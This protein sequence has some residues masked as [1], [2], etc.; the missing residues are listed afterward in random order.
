MGILFKY[1]ARSIKKNI[2]PAILIFLS[3]AFSSAALYLNL[4]ISQD[5][6]EV[7]QKAFKGTSGGYDLRVE[8]DDGYELVDDSLKLDEA[9]SLLFISYDIKD[10]LLEEK[11]IH[12]LG[13][14]TNVNEI[15]DCEMISLKEGTLPQ[16]INE[17]IISESKAELYSYSVG[18]IIEFDSQEYIVT[19]IA[20]SLGYFGNEMPNVIEIISPYISGSKTTTFLIDT[21]MDPE[22]C[23]K[24]LESEHEGW[25]VDPFEENLFINYTGAIRAVLIIVILITMLLGGFIIY[26]VTSMMID[27]RMSAMASFRSVGATKH[28]VDSLL[29]LECLFYGVLGSAFGLALGEISRHLLV[30]GIT[31]T[32]LKSSINLLYLLI[33]FLFGIILEIVIVGISLVRKRPLSI[34]EILFKKPSTKDVS[35]LPCFIVGMTILCLSIILYVLNR[36]YNLIINFVALFISIVSVVLLL[37]YLTSLI[38]SLFNK[39]AI[40][41]KHGNVYLASNNLKSSKI[42]KNNVSL[43][44]IVLSLSLVVC[45]ISGSMNS[46]YKEYEQRFPYDAVIKTTDVTDSELLELAT[47][48][49]VGKVTPE[50]WRYIRYTDINGVSSKQPVTFVK[51]DEDTYGI[52]VDSSLVEVLK[53][54]EII[55]D[56]MFAK[57]IDAS[58]GKTLSF[59]FPKDGNYHAFSGKIVGYCDSSIFNIKRAT[60]IMNITDFKSNITPSPRIIGVSLQE[61]YSLSELM[62]ILGLLPYEYQGR[63]IMVF[64][65]EAFLGEELSTIKESMTLVK[66]LPVLVVILAF[67]GLL[68]NQLVMFS[69]K[70]KEYA[71]LYSTCCGKSD[72]VKM[73]FFE[74]LVT[75]VLGLVFAS[76]FSILLTN[77]VRDIIYTLMMYVAIKVTLIESLVVVVSAIIL[78]SASLIIANRLIK[79]INIVEELKYE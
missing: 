29:I 39:I 24:K 31:K 68:N 27:S 9:T 37:P 40:N 11:N 6:V 22:E 64:T 42:S 7:S 13:I 79:K 12:Q 48:K 69:K 30:S 67:F 32:A 55:I 25:D 18:D 53:P 16:S 3:I 51:A 44:T 15:L 34:K 20:G 14:R 57:S 71:T 75:I 61:G 36:N 65:K 59:S 73:L 66:M 26:T 52:N 60:V 62:S 1:I 35:K 19:A 10:S 17:A 28:K 43:L 76:L 78:I 2:V 8:I 4:N 45:F 74:L 50:Y 38:A 70:K 46:Y 5:V 72:L 23:Y 47:L 21:E 58:I 41:K 77:I 33:C 49:G 63:D 56:K 54:N